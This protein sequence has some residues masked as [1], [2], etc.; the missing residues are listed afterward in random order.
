LTVETEANRDLWG[1][2]K[3]VLPWLVSRAL[4]ASIRDFYPAL[5]ALVSQAQNI[6]FL[7]GHYFNPCVPIAQQPGQA[8]VQGRQSLNLC[9][10]YTYSVLSCVAN[11]LPEFEFAVIRDHVVLKI[12]SRKA[13]IKS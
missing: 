1:K 7:T 3:G 10:W 2:M 11:T 5:L 9:L 6:F 12:F 8:V 4:R 13:P